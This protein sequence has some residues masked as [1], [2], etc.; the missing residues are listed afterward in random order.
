MP[1]APLS[2]EKQ[3]KLFKYVRDLFCEKYY[4]SDPD[5][6][7]IS[8]GLVAGNWIQST[9]LWLQLISPPS[10]GKT[11]L[12]RTIRG[13]SECKGVDK[14]SSHCFN[15][16]YRPEGKN[17][18]K[19]ENY[20]LLSTL[21]GKVMVTMDFSTTL[22]GSR[23]K[24]N[25]IFGQI[26]GIYDGDEFTAGLGNQTDGCKSARAKFNWIVGMTPAIDKHWHLN[27]LGDR[28][29]SFRLNIDD[30]R[31]HIRQ[32]LELSEDGTLDKTREEVCGAVHDMLSS[33][34]QILPTITPAMKNRLIDLSEVL[35]TC[36]T[37]LD[38]DKD[39]NLYTPPLPEYGTRIAQQLLRVA[40]SVALV[41]GH[42]GVEESDFNL[43]KRVAFDTLL[44]NRSSLLSTLWQ[45]QGTPLFNNKIAKCMGVAEKTAKRHLDDLVDLGVVVSGE[46][47]VTGPLSNGTF[48]GYLLG[49]KFTE[50]LKS[51]GGVPV[52]TT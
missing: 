39:G 36:R 5:I 33:V 1:I 47:G 6:V 17:K 14:F 9:P 31:A 28:F 20:D 45:N 41:R 32:G 8:L 30:R 35:A 52:T 24:L 21:Q 16:G 37:F 23:E 43:M 12:L 4:Y 46:V 18:D 48:K 19:E 7:D 40:Q 44:P 26:R 15:S 25:D 2:L 13:F 38:R 49:P 42:I 50:Y 10:S 27:Q 11:E 51:I 29:L 3:G 34:P 22:E